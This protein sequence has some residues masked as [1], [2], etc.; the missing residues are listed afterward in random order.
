[1]K[2]CASTYSR[3]STGPDG[4]C[5]ET[6]NFSHNRIAILLS[7]LF[8]LCLSHG[9]LPP[10]MIETTIVPIVKNKC[11]NITDSNNYRPIALATIVSKLFES[12][13]LMKCE[14]YLTTSA[15]QFGFKTGHSTDLCIYA[16]KK[17]IEHYKSRNTTV[18]VTFLDASKAFD[19]IDH[20]LLFKK[21]ISK[22]VPLFRIRLLVYWYSHQQMCVRWGNIVSSCFCV[23]NGVKQGGILSPTLFNVYMD[24]LSISLNSTNIGGHIGGQLLN[25]LCYADD[26][27][28]ISMSSAG[29]QRLLN[30]CKDYAEQ[31][32][33][34]YNGS[35][36]F[37]MC[38]KSKTIKFERP[39]LF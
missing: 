17:F 7:L 20:W 27:C 28:L 13:I 21:L 2:I 30:M 12:V 14:Q 5:A 23:S 26:L 1:M 29:M 35:K 15:N 25:H 34:H 4:V 24:I 38:Y 10:A 32:A 3:K 36:S 18:F 8:T 37:S 39:D 33:L 11:G 6:I 19:R 22:D 31:H 16:L 9:Y